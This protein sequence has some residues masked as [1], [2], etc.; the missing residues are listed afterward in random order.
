MDIF[1][2]GFGHVAA[3]QDDILITGKDDE[4]HIQNLNTVLSRLDSYGLRHLLN[5][6]KSMHQSVTY[7]ACFISAE[8]TPPTEDKVEAIKKAPRPENC[9]QLRA[10]LGMIN[11]H[12]KF[13]C[14]LSSIL[15]PLNQLL[16]KDQKN[17]SLSHMCW[18]ITIL[19]SQ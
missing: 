7:M 8:G 14:N 12:G 9:T 11:Y 5:K 2:Q 1:L 3:I 16:Q 4:H 15:Q 19:A 10:F 13:I 18:C 17:P 6:C